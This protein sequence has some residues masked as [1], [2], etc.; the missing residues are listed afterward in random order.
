MSPYG[1]GGTRDVAGTPCHADFAGSG[2]GTANP[3]FV[4][5]LAAGDRG[6]EGRCRRAT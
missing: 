4:R 6:G 2:G 1:F 3:E 5:L